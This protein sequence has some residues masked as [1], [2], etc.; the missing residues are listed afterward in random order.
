MAA[1]TDTAGPD[2]MRA[3]GVWRSLVARLLWE[4]EAGG[5]NPLT[6]TNTKPFRPAG[7]GVSALR[8]DTH[9]DA[10]KIVAENAGIAQLVEHNLAKVGVASSSL[11]SRS[12]FY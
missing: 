7:A 11:V 2:N 8:L 9:G 6:P 10:S 3:D 5:S 4:Q 12:R 1:L